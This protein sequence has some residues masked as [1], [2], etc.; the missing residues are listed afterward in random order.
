[1]SLE[2]ERRVFRLIKQ[3]ECETFES[4]VKRV[5]AQSDK[6]EF[7]DSV[8]CMK[9]QIVQKCYDCKLRVALSL[10]HKSL[11]ELILIGRLYEIIDR[12]CKENLITLVKARKEL[13]A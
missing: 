12:K 3:E 6:C 4:F 2:N 11:D 8:S 9:L 10:N 5:K 7:A 13:N 1:M